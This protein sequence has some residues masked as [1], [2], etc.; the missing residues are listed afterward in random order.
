MSYALNDELGTSRGK[1]GR[2][3]TRAKDDLRGVVEEILDVLEDL[4]P[5]DQAAARQVAEAA[6]TLRE[7]L[8]SGAAPR[9]MREAT[10]ELAK[11]YQRFKQ[12]PV[13]DVARDALRGISKSARVSADEARI[14]MLLRAA[15][16]WVDQAASTPSKFSEYYARAAAARAEAN[17]IRKSLENTSTSHADDIARLVAWAVRARGKVLDW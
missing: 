5:G 1:P 13:P 11:S 9:E 14:E 2:D 4:M 16:Y 17:R 7:K 10:R 3:R 8:H 12:R 15:D 6:R